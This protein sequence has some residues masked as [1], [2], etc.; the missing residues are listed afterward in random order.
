MSSNDFLIN[1]ATRHQIFVQ[2]YAGGQ[3]KQLLKHLQNMVADVQRELAAATTLAQAQRLA[4][5]LDS[6]QELIGEGLDALGSDLRANM[7]EFAAFEADFAVRAINEAASV[8]AKLPDNELL[9]S[10]VTQNPMRLLVGDSEQLLTISEAVEQFSAKKRGEIARLIQTG[11]L[12]GKTTAQVSRDVANLVEKRT[13]SQ[14][15]ALIR[16]ATNHISSEAR[17]AT[18]AANTDIIEGE[19]WVATLDGRTTLTCA[20]LDGKT[21]DI[22][23]G[24]QTP[25]TG[26]AAASGCRCLSRNIR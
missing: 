22:G 18:H 2:R 15:T 20:S 4:F 5:R 19:E 25:G 21:F 23:D 11:L 7:D 16:T 12:E 1:S 3:V 14:A 24:P 10:L 8:G 9:A 13:R 26:I 17:A 6:I